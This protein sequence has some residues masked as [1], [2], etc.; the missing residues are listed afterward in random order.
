MA[1]LRKLK[2]TFVLLNLSV[3]MLLFQNCGTRFESNVDMISGSSDSSSNDKVVYVAN[4]TSSDAIAD[5][6]DLLKIKIFIVNAINDPVSGVVPKYTIRGDYE[7]ARACTESDSN[8]VSECE[9]KSTIA[10]NYELS[11]TYPSLFVTQVEFKAGA[12]DQIKVLQGGG[13]SGSASN[14]LLVEPKFKVIDKNNNPIKNSKVT[15]SVS[16][17]GSVSNSEVITNS[18]GEVSPGTWV[19]GTEGVNTLTASIGSLTQSMTAIAVA[20]NNNPIKIVYLPT[21]SCS[22]GKVEVYI[23]NSPHPKHQFVNV[24]ECIEIEKEVAEKS[25]KVRCIDPNDQMLPSDFVGPA[26][27]NSG[28]DPA[29]ACS[30]IHK[31]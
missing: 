29:S 4:V 30:T 6:S 5:G 12:P 16:N 20:P 10:A 7:V 15:F 9:I 17:N 22:T 26:V 18:N 3:L 25:L 24:G 23:N 28:R 11:V 8:G 21:G 31:G 13:Q 27:I 1:I 14:A 19:L 2:I